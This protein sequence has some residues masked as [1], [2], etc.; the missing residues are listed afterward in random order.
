MQ[1]ADQHYSGSSS[2]GA[3]GVADEQD[4]AIEASIFEHY[5]ATCDAAAVDA[6]T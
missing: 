3:G 4:S 2:D 6:D 1:A 5:L